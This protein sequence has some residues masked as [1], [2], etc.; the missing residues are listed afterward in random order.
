MLCTAANNFR[1][2]FCGHVNG[3]RERHAS[4]TYA[5]S[6]LLSL[7]CRCVTVATAAAAAAAV[8]CSCCCLLLLL[9]AASAACCCCLLLL[10][11]AAT[12]AVAA[13]AAAACCCWECFTSTATRMRYIHFYCQLPGD[14][15]AVTAVQLFDF[16]SVML[17]S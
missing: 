12:A 8:C 3:T 13:A 17:G 15:A 4:Y 9:L 1:K 11:L 16:C 6:K 7:C 14:T 5:L 2:F 10:L